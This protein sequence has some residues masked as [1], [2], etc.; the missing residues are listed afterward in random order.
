MKAARVCAYCRPSPYHRPQTHAPNIHRRSASAGYDRP[1]WLPAVKCGNVVTES[2]R[3]VG[4]P[5]GHSGSTMGRQAPSGRDGAHA[6]RPPKTKASHARRTARYTLRTLPPPARPPTP[7]TRNTTRP[8]HH[9]LHPLSTMA[10]RETTPTASVSNAAKY[11][12]AVVE[13]CPPPPPTTPYYHVQTL[14][15]HQD[16]QLPPAFCVPQDA[17]LSLA[18]E[19]AYEREFDQLPSV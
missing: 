11:R 19:K 15:H 2:W 17:P 18:L 3:L 6:A 9:L 4:A 8:S 13:V 1:R 10:D 7:P 12:G 16:L 14:I 5:S